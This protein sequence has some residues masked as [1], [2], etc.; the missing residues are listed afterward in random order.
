MFVAIHNTLNGNTFIQINKLNNI[1]FNTQENQRLS[2]ILS[3]SNIN[4][5][6]K[7]NILGQDLLIYIT[8]LAEA[9][10]EIDESEEKTIIQVNPML[11]FL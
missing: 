6:V 8:H 11:T 5:E 9:F 4:D 10:Y 1:N 7:L 3:M 2:V